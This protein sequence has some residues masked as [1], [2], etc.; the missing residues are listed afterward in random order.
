M[1]NGGK[2]RSFFSSLRGKVTMQML[3]VAL[4]PVI[5][6][7]V[8]ALY[9][10]IS[11]ESQANDSVDEA[12]T[13][14]QED[15]VGR[16]LGNEAESMVNQLSTMIG[17]IVLD[18]TQ[19]ASSPNVIQLAGGAGDVA[20]TT[21]FLATQRSLVSLGD[22]SVFGELSVIDNT[23][24]VLA[25]AHEE[26]IT[27]NVGEDLSDDSWYQAM[28]AQLDIAGSS[29]MAYGGSERIE[30]DQLIRLRF[31]MFIPNPAAPTAVD[32]RL[33]M[34][35][36][37]MYMNTGA[38]ATL[39]SGRVTDST[40]IC[41]TSTGLLADTNDTTRPF[42]LTDYDQWEANRTDVE[43][44]VV[45]A[46]ADDLEEDPSAAPSGYVIVGDDVAG[47]Y[48][49]SSIGSM[50][51]STVSGITVILSQPQTTAFA[52][53]ASLDTLEDDLNSSTN[54]M[55]LT[56][57][58]VLA[59]VI[60]LGLIV[61]FMLSNSITKPVAQLTEVADKVSMG[62]LDVKLPPPTDDEIGDLTQSFERMV[63]AVRYLSQDEEK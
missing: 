37:P 19:T 45:A 20:T 4:I 36:A 21:S 3:S 24:T 18:I 44:A 52:S 33:G 46:I 55:I 48:Q 1:A 8:L 60:I 50:N 47:Y 25:T 27:R 32:Q 62:D 57:A 17:T 31:G 26:G 14:M 6:V 41:Y 40:V 16:T 23:G 10:S 12:R 35:F 11:A 15:V 63:T 9:F 61:S 7:G 2:Q 51:L 56:V 22:Q 34:L 42:T 38:M 13:T 5:I 54:T 49:S 28:N 58:L 53:L 30:E 59:I 39:Y 29:G 43:S